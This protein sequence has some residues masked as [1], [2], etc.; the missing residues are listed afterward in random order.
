MIFTILDCIPFTIVAKVLVVVANVLVVLLALIAASEALAADDNTKLP[1]RVVVPLRVDEVAVRGPEIL[2]VDNCVVPVAFRL[3]VFV[4]PKLAT[5]AKRFWKLAVA[6]V[7]KLEIR[8]CSDKLV[9]VALPKVKLLALVVLAFKIF[10]L[11][12]LANILAATVVPSKDK[13]VSPLMVAVLVMPSTVLVIKLVVDEKLKVF[14]VVAEMS[15]AMEVVEITPFTLVVITPV[16]VEKVTRLLDMTDEVADTP[17]T[18][19]V[20]VFPVTP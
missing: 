4:V 20:K 17:F 11:I 16:E 12:L 1:L 19:V 2:V 13:L 9:P 10:V 8:F 14:V 18:V 15:E 3:V 7:T 5:F 6:A